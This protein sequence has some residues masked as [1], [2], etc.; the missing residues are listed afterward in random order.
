M[1]QGLLIQH[2][3]SYTRQRWHGCLIGYAILAISLFIKMY[4]APLLPKI[5]STVLLLHVFGSFFVSIPLVY[6]GPH[7]DPSTVLR[8]FLNEGHWPT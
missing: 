3:S 7:G 8:Q 5:E 6:F 4:L 1:K 2:D